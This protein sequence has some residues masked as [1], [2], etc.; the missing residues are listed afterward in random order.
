MADMTTTERSELLE[1]VKRLK[2]THSIDLG[3]GVVTPGQWGDH[4]PFLR[5]AIGDIG[6]RGKKV[7]DIGCWDGLWSFEAEKR[8]AAE[9]YATDLITHRN[10]Q[11]PTF[12]FAQQI[13]NSKVKYYPR[14][15]VYDVETLGIND[16]DVVI[17]AGVYYHLKDPV[18][19]LCTL[20]RVMKEGAILIVEGAVIDLDRSEPEGTS[21]VVSRRDGLGQQL[22]RFLRLD[23][24]APTPSPRASTANDC[25]ARFYYRN[26]FAFDNSNWWVPT[27]PCLRQWVEC[28]FFEIERDYGKWDA[29]NDNLRYT[30]TARA[31]CRKDPLYCREEDDLRPFDLNSY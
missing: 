13:L 11:H 27:I 24:P 23:V 12:E 4:S 19:A 16:F 9:V 30:L 28:N 15:S 14:L 5:K 20:R 22:R 6:F 7:L 31:V 10:N 1:Q 8:G 25:F 26:A 21:H 3:N 29:G 18:R 17:F 2:W